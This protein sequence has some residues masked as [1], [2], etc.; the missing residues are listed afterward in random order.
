MSRA[1][2]E[3]ICGQVGQLWRVVRERNLGGRRKENRRERIKS[4]C[5][6]HAKT[7]PLGDAGLLL[8]ESS[9]ERAPGP[10]MLIW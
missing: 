7:R 3:V 5:S 8:K 2:S 10:A 9:W 6:K 4:A 1:V